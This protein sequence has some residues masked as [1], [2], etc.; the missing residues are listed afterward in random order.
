MNRVGLTVETYGFK[1]LEE[2]FNNLS[3]KK[4][5]KRILI[6]AFKRSTKVTADY[7][8]SYARKKTGN[9]RK[10]IGV[11]T[12][13]G[14]KEIG[15]YVGA[16]IKGG[17]KGYHGHILE[18]GTVARYRKTKNNAPTGKM[19][20]TG[21]MRKAALYTEPQVVNSVSKEW[22]DAIARHIIRSHRRFLKD[23]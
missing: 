6:D 20:Y 10:S 3:D 4:D 2:L 23:I 15:V 8:K 18:Y 1:S 9:L 7:A 22:Y 16:R 19:K 14:N 12:I 21:F 17:Y 11:V 13:P 5:Q